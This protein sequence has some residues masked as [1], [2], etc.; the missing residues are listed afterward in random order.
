MADSLSPLKQGINPFTIP[1]SHYPLFGPIDNQ[2][3]NDWILIDSTYYAP[4]ETYEG[5][6]HLWTSTDLITWTDQGVIREKVG[7][8]PGICFDGRT[9]HL[10]SENAHT[11]SHSVL[12]LDSMQALYNRN[13]LD[14]GDH[15]GDAD[16]SYFNN[17]WH[18]FMDDGIHLHYKISYAAAEPDS[19]PYGWQLYPEIYGPHNPEQGQQWDDD[20]P[21]GNDFGTGDADIALEGNTIYLFTERPVGVAYKELTEL[22]DLSDQSVR[23]MIETDHNGD[24]LPNDSTGWEIMRGGE[25]AAAL[26]R[27]ISG[28]KFRIRL[29]LGSRKS[30]ESPLIRYIEMIEEEV[31]PYRLRLNREKDENL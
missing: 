22:A 11:I 8:D 25:T 2:A 29:K 27:V 13:V 7:S 24:G 1:K 5:M 19:F 26:N 18:M 16:V 30:D 12:D 14:V 28:T 9:F 4:D 3:P 31:A 6:S 23:F 15:T 17:Q 10:F 20:N 21:K